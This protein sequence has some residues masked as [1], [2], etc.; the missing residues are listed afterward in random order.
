MA[1]KK[2]LKA[3]ITLAGKVD[4]SLQA[5]LMKTTKSTRSL[6]EGFKQS[7]RYVA[8]FSELVKASFLGGAIASGVSILTSKV[9]ELGK[10]SIQLASDLVEV[11]NVVDTTF[12]Q[13]ASQID[14]WAKTTLNAYGIT[15]LQAKQWSG[16]MGAMLKS[17]NIAS[18][19]MLIMST[20]LAGLAG[21][22]ASF[23]NLDHDN[24]W[25]K[26][27][28]GIAGESEPLKELGINMSVANLE[29]YA[30]AQG[31]KKSFSD[32]S[33][34]EQTLLRYNYLM[35]VSADAQG[36]FA[37]TS[38]SFSNQQKLLTN[39]IKQLSAT[40]AS[41]ALPFLTKLY[42]KANEFVSNIDVDKVLGVFSKVGDFIQ[43]LIPHIESLGDTIKQTFID[44]MPNLSSFGE[45]FAT[46]ISKGTPPLFK[47]IESIVKLG[48]GLINFFLPILM[49]IG[50]SVGP[51][52][53]KIGEGL[54]PLLEK[55]ATMFTVLGPLVGEV[56]G[57]ILSAF[58]EF[59]PLVD[60]ILQALGGVIDFITGVF[61]GDWQLAWQGV[62]N[63]FSGMMN[64]LKEIIVAPINF[65][66]NIVNGLIGKIN[67]I[68][69]PE[70]VPLIG[71]KSLDL[72]MLPT[73]ARGGIAT[74]A[75]IF[76]EAG[77][78]M[79]IPLKRTSRSF[80][81]LNQTA[82]ILGVNPSQENSNFKMGSTFDNFGVKEQTVIQKTA[83]ITI[84]VI[85][86][87]VEQ[88][89]MDIKSKVKEALEELEYEEGVIAFG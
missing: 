52:L 73:F 61:K 4:P 39:N 55:A 18:E 28:S 71:G 66:S 32:M 15:E 47:L 9:M 33:Q 74:Q 24:A 26:I 54:S 22:F 31:I 60:S 58:D 13:N 17:S 75:S 20:N 3:L 35:E 81:L 57:V 30:L 64:G 70:W 50:E 37:R 12:G 46:L 56:I 25:Q 86:E 23:Y 63:I 5:S 53:I 78:E 89:T 21:D 85:G 59:M 69:I 42:K 49:K 43:P 65:I 27:R 36:D 14:A 77:P 29:A 80:E 2:E 8:K 68:S 45:G 87:V 82:Q 10:E 76:G 38:D 72:P 6:S 67:E 11:Q 19:D 16:S 88:T 84:Q 1:S 83:N 48:G 51:I 7:T 41:K 44:I 40:I 34:A 79:A 62:V